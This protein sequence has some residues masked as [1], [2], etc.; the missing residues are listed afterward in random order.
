M[1]SPHG[2]YFNLRR[3][4]LAQY[5]ARNGYR[6]PDFTEARRQLGPSLRR[7]VRGAPFPGKARRTVSM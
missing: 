5:L 2:S 7:T 6:L 4:D 3:Q 1:L